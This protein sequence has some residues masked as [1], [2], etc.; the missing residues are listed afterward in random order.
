MIHSIHKMKIEEGAH[1][2]HFRGRHRHRIA[3]ESNFLRKS[4]K[5]KEGIGR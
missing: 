4:V 2:A 3:N 5:A 1:R